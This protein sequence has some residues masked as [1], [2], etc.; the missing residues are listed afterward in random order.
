MHTK[1]FNN[2]PRIVFGLR[3]HG[4][5]TQKGESAS[6]EPGIERDCVSLRTNEGDNE[7]NIFPCRLYH[8]LYPSLKI[9]RAIRN[10]N[11]AL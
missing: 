10:R 3:N 9:R 11:T 6:D 8:P 1:Y 4:L 2:E 7:D 5:L